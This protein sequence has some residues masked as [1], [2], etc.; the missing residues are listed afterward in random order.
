MKKNKRN[1]QESR[2]S[3]RLT[4]LAPTKQD[5]GIDDPVELLRVHH[6][7]TANDLFLK[8]KELL[9]SSKSIIIGKGENAFEKVVP[10]HNLQ[11]E[12]LKDTHKL[13]GDYP[14]PKKKDGGGS[15]T[16]PI[17]CSITIVT[18]SN[19][20]KTEAEVFAEL[21]SAKAIDVGPKQSSIIDVSPKDEEKIHEP[22]KKQRPASR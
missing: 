1:S 7:L 18:S 3:N 14:E 6:G 15:D 2:A 5:I 19:T 10:N 11:F 8:R 21:G 12:V 22:K 13:F 17:S 16:R 20:K 9:N 4:E